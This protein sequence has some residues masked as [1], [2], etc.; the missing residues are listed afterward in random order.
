[1]VGI[2]PNITFRDMYSTNNKRVMYRETSGNKT[3]LPKVKFKFLKKFFFLII[4]S[5]I[6][7]K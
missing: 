5:I 6:V 2:S 1:M 4:F 3:F 7:Y